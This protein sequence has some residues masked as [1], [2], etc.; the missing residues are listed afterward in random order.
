MSEDLVA[1]LKKQQG[2]CTKLHTSRETATKT[3]FV[4]SHKIAKKSKP[5][6]EGEF[7][8]EC[9]MNSA[10]LICPKKREAF[11]N[12]SL[13]RHTMTRRIED[14]AGNLELQLQHEVANFDFFS[15]AL[16]ESCDVQ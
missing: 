5:F 3:S 14:I 16:D 7:V 1:K 4:I 6:S 8:K 2:L 12:I 15:L 13:S 9:L 11:E 10:A